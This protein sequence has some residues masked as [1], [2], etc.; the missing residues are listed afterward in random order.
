MTAYQDRFQTVRI[1]GHRI[2]YLDEGEGPP[3]RIL[4]S[5]LDRPPA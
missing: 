4:G 2:A 3:G 5:F 1:E